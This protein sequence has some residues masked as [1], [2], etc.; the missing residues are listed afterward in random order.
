MQPVYRV[1]HNELY[2][3]IDGRMFILVI[4]PFKRTELHKYWLLCGLNPNK[5]WEHKKTAQSKLRG[6][7]GCL[8][9]GSSLHKN[10]LKEQIT[11]N[12]TNGWMKSGWFL[13]AFHPG[14]LFS[15]KLCHAIYNTWHNPDH[16][17]Y[18]CALVDDA[19]HTAYTCYKCVCYWWS[20]LV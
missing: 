4:Y 2:F 13:P 16:T 14:K 19:F 18:A 8:M 1:S 10:C 5:V 11:I 3:F 7:F 20:F 12:A 17:A 6:K 9:Y 15:R